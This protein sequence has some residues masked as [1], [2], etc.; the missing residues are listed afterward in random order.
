M[1]NV[2][3]KR[4]QERDTVREIIKIYCHGQQ[5]K[6]EAGEKLCPDCQA[7]AAYAD[8]RIAKCPRMDI[9]T[10][11]NVCPIHCYAPKERAQIQR[12][13]AYGGPRMLLHHPVMTLRH[14]LIQW[15]TKHGLREREAVITQKKHIRDA[16]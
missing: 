1:V 12:I 13:M 6:R 14:L 16:K 8:E 11:C 3:K 15:R 5:H 2:E 10:F 4:Q 7:I 9:K